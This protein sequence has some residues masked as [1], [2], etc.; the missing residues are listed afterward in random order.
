MN[1]VVN[2]SGSISGE[3]EAPP[4]KLH[5]QISSALAILAGGKSTIDSPLRVQDTNVMLKAA[6]SLGATVKRTEERWTIWGVGGEIK[7]DKNVIDAKNSGTAM[8]LLTSITTLSPTSIVLTGDA[9]L[10]SR[11]M[12]TF[13][14]A[15]RGLGADVYSIKP[16]DSPPFLVFG[17][18]LSGGK[19]KLNNV[20]NR[21][22]PAVLLVT[23]YAKKKVEL[24]L[25]GGVP[26]PMVEIMKAARVKVV[27]KRNSISVPRQP[28]HS[29]NYKVP[30]EVTGAAPFIVAACLA[31][32]KVKVTNVKTMFARDA[33]FLKNLKTLGL[34]VHV[35]GKSIY[36]EGQRRLKAA[37]LNLASIPELLPL[38][39]V[40]ACAAK[41]NTMLYGAEEAREMK[42]DRISAIANELRRM[43]AKLLE[44]NDGL[45]I[46]GP[47]KLKGCEVDGH[48][49][50]AITTALIVAALS[51]EG[52]TTIKNGFESLGVNFS[53]F[54]STFQG[55][56]AEI[57]HG[58]LPA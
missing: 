24:I 46:Y 31:G 25:R 43:R 30:S 15:L 17:G 36:T 32:S 37:R 39:A 33:E 51:A 22:L 53:R 58:N 55:L 13:L 3:V 41:G 42:S 27:A 49:D 19:V 1:L 18:G 8:S 57:S 45:L 16:E 23:P 47:T 28:Y 2:A 44:K 34:G 40:V 7:S 26:E 4:S 6:E 50:Y 14:N 21:F 56:G 5:T 12:P 54:I 48:E 20:R 9:Q 35:S 10:R 52:K 29:F 38:F 11:P